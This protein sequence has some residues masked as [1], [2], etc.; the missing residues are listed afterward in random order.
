M[1][2]KIPAWLKEEPEKKPEDQPVI[3]H[4]QPIRYEELLNKPADGKG[5]EAVEFKE[6]EEESGTGALLERPGFYEFLNRHLKG[7]PESLNQET[8]NNFYG[9]FEAANATGDFY[10]DV[11]KQESGVEVKDEEIRAGLELYFVNSPDPKFGEQTAALMR[12]YYELPARIAAKE[13]EVIR[14]GGEAVIAERLAE[15]EA[16]EKPAMA[17]L[18]TL[19]MAEARLQEKKIKSETMRGIRGFFNWRNSEAVRFIFGAAELGTVVAEKFISGRAKVHG[20]AKEVQDEIKEARGKIQETQKDIRKHREAKALTSAGWQERIDA[21]HDEMRKE[22]EKLEVAR[23]NAEVLRSVQEQY[24]GYR[25]R[26][27]DIRRLMFGEYFGPASDILKIANAK[28]R[29]KLMKIIDPELTKQEDQIPNLEEGL[30]FLEK[31]RESDVEILEKADQ[32]KFAQAFEDM[33]DF[34]ARFDIG[35]ILKKLDISG[36][37][38]KVE[39]ELRKLFDAET[40]GAKKS[41]VSKKYVQDRLAEYIKAAKPAG[42]SDESFKAKKLA[43]KLFLMKLS[44]E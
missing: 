39:K 40:Y 21:V 24:R 15:E 32:K 5:E 18:G 37:F 20:W 34:K 33:L 16:K 23:D 17:R 41:G 13:E 14:L 44:T 1:S 9:A 29:G 12:E 28:V 36:S 26:M 35:R 3:K 11:L 38:A 6:I 19:G 4:P 30:E 10:R 8:L 22:T 27:A 2:E 25:E 42:E 31:L 7:D 43:V